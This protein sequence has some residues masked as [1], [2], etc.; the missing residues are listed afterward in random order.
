MRKVPFTWVF[1]AAVVLLPIAVYGL[2]RWYENKYVPLPY[3]GPPNHRIAAFSLTD[4]NNK[5]SEL[6]DWRGKI[7]VAH[8]FFTRCPNICP[9]MI[10]NLKRVQ[11]YAD[12]D[13]L[14]IASFTVDPERDSPSALQAYAQKFDL[15][16]NWRLLTGNKEQLYRLARKSFLITATDGDGGPNDFIHSENLVLIDKAQKIRGFY[17]GTN[18]DAVNQLAK[19]IAKLAQE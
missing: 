11:A 4:Q 3:L 9:K 7:V 18:E 16:G 14:L 12:A 1:V 13:N 2:V 10:Y 19:D 17:N 5:K 8:F 15:K 6:Q